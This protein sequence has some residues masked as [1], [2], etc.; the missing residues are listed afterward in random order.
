MRATKTT[1]MKNKKEWISLKIRKKETPRKKNIGWKKE[2]K[3]I[4]FKRTGVE[5]EKGKIK[6]EEKSG[7]EREIM[8][9]K[10]EVN[11]ETLRIEGVSPMMKMTDG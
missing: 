11:Q 10:V 6:E 1:K 8:E 3:A 7:I 5:F 2:I 4:S 9:I